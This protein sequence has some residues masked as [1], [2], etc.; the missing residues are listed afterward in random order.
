VLRDVLE[1]HNLSNVRGVKELAHTLV[2][3]NGS[4]VS[5]KRLADL[6]VSRNIPMSREMTTQVCSH[7]EDA[8]L[9]FF[10]PVYAYGLQKTRVN[11]VKVYASD[12]GLAFAMSA[13]PTLNLG[14]R[15]E[16][17]V[18]LELRRRYPL[19]RGGGISYY[20]TEGK[21]RERR[22][23]DF[24][25]GDPARRLPQALFQVCASLKEPAT[26]E[27]EITALSAAME[28]LGLKTARV[29]TL[30]EREKIKT[31]AGRIDVVPAWEW[32]L[33]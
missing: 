19:L 6:L 8:F 28:E 7:L 14:Q 30:Y 5:M 2:A 25:L 10:V 13:A 16:Q 20:L 31:R 3:N 29:I 12:P 32:F 9:V 17:A 21:G 15:F 11:P 33:E 4:L 1:R 27:R 26:R 18:Y 22:E 24:V 23:V